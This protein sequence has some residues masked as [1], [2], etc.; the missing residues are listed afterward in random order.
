[1]LDRTGAAAQND[2][3]IRFRNIDAFIQDARCHQNGELTVTKFIENPFALRR[4]C[5][6][7]YGGNEKDFGNTI[8]QLVAECKDEYAVFGM[9]FQK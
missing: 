1:M 7:G 9:F 6:M 3:D 4:F 8:D 2:G 5:L